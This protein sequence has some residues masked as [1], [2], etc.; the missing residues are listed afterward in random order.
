[1]PVPSAKS[2]LKLLDKSG[3]VEDESLKDTLAKLSQKAAGETVALSQLTRHLVDS[4]LITQWHCEKLMLGKYKG[5]FLGKFKLLGLLGAG[6]MSTVYLAEHIISGHRRAIK[7]LPRKKATDPSYLDR[8]YREG[9]AAASLNHPNVVRIYDICSEADT[10]Y[11]VMEHVR[12]TD[13]YQR[14]KDQGPLPIHEAVEAIIQSCSGLQ[15]A[16]D[17]ELVHRD[18]KPANLLQMADGT[19][20]ILDLGLALFDLGE[21]DES[22]TVLYNERVMGTADYLSPEQAVNSHEV[23]HR[24]DIYSMGCTLYYLLT[25]HPPFPKGTLAQRIAMHQTQRSQAI[26]ESRPECSQPLSDICFAMMAKL[27]EA[28]YQSCNDLVQELRAWQETGRQHCIGLDKTA[29]Q[30][31][32]VLKTVPPADATIISSLLPPS[33]TDPSDQAG[34]QARHPTDPQVDSA[35]FAI[36]TSGSS[37]SSKARGSSSNI[38]HDS[39]GSLNE[40]SG[41]RSSFVRTKSFRKIARTTRKH[42]WIVPVM[43]AI[44]FLILIAVVFVAVSM[45]DVKGRDPAVFEV[46]ESVETGLDAIDATRDWTVHDISKMR[47]S[48][49]VRSG[50]PMFIFH[51]IAVRQT[52]LLHGGS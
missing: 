48:A 30:G 37:A 50:I 44:M 4:G 9:K 40:P 33:S 47:S 43:I 18:I 39:G 14:V 21:D 16:H 5:F 19:V 20:K 2:F 7:V 36:D 12:G 32:F 27:P 34:A 51:P 35:V 6:G 25:G 24:A 3:I 46:Y 42:K 26:Q 41:S 38:H 45:A 8:F 15:H 22:L 11:M 29:S 10:H 31:T 1:M 52:A 28:R 13:L 23:D 49:P 17:R